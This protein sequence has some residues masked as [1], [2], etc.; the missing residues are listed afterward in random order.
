MQPAYIDHYRAAGHWSTRH[1]LF[2]GVSGLLGSDGKVIMHTEVAV[3]HM[4]LFELLMA[5]PSAHM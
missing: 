3:V 2:V 4:T 5:Y 1:E